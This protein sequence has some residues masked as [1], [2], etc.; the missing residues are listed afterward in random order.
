MQRPASLSNPL[1]RRGFSLAELLIV[2]ALLL[3]LAGLAAPALMDRLA[4]SQVY[5]AAESVREVL[6]EARTFAIDTGIDYQFRYEVN[7]QYFVV[8]P[9]EIEPSTANSV[10]DDS[11]SSEYLRLSGQLNE[12]IQLRAADESSG[13]EERQATEQLSPAWF[14]GLPD[15]GMLSSKSWS[16]PIA[17][18]FDGS[19]SDGT[20]RVMDE[21]GRTADISVRGLTGAVRL[22][23]VY[24]EQPE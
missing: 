19:A 1:Q 22:A 20:F 24:R 17:F 10:T 18:H 8:L 7:G 15:A 21:S 9:E 3:A 23:A 13:D 14:G 16:A 5:R 4:E 6:A 2:L 11:D 12:G